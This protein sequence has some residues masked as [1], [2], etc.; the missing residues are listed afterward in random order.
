MILMGEQKLRSN[1]RRIRS[2]ERRIRTAIE[3]GAGAGPA[4]CTS[5]SSSCEVASQT[6]ADCLT[7]PTGLLMD[8]FRQYDFKI[9]TPGEEAAKQ[10]LKVLCTTFA[11]NNLLSQWLTF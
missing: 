9:N 5:N 6:H 2:N 1:E 8:A 11:D 4:C 7:V 3:S 10:I